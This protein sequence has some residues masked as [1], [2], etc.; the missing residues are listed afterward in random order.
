[1]NGLLRLDDG[2][3]VEDRVVSMLGRPYRCTSLWGI[4]F[5]VALY[6]NRR[7]HQLSLY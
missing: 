6:A 3:F 2:A 7:G 4:E 5:G 1:M